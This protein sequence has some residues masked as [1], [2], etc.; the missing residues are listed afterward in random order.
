MNNTH[1]KLS[2]IALSSIVLAASAIFAVSNN[3]VN[4]PSL[5]KASGDSYSV[6]FARNDAYSDS[7][8]TYVYKQNTQVGNDIY[9]VS[10]GGMN[11]NS[12]AIATIPSTYES[13]YTN[14]ELKFY[15]DSG[16]TQPFMHQEIESVSIKTS[17]SVTLS[18]LT[19]FDNV[20]YKEVGTLSCSSSG[21]TFSTFN[22]Y[23]RFLKIGV[24]E[25]GAST[26]NI[27]QVSF[28][29]V[30]ESKP[31]VAF[32]SGS[33]SAI[34]KDK[35]NLDTEMHMYFN[36]DGYG[37][38]TFFYNYNSTTYYTLFSWVYNE[39][40][41]SFVVTYVHNDDKTGS[42][43]DLTPSGGTTEYQGYRLFYSNSR[44]KTTSVGYVNG[45]VAL[46][47]YTAQGEQY[48]RDTMNVLS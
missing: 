35:S 14:P 29:Y 47:F 38:Y 6:T 5:L 16:A 33:F 45:K 41:E 22:E 7:G 25:K 19:S 32:V 15:R 20:T 48:Q 40:Y 12:G 28:S 10:T 26:R 9:L 11:R 46:Y 2:I 17:G 1:K 44:G 36:S 37:Y 13:S 27:T 4:N 34:V 42:I 43:A 3:V 24:S 23:D 8:T 39:A 31:S 30:C 21:A 18:I